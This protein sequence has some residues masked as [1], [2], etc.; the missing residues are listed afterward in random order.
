L[1][2]SCLST[3]LNPALYKRSRVAPKRRLPSVA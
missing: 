3:G 1:T 2:I